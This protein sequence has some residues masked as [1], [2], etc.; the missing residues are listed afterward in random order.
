MRKLADLTEKAKPL[1]AKLNSIEVQA[2]DITPLE[3]EWTPE[4][5]ER[6]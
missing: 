4:P 5:G 6:T 2:V 3:P 1:L